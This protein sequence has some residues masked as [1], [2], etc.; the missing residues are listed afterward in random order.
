MITIDRTKASRFSL[1]SG[2]IISKITQLENEC[3][4][5]FEHVHVRNKNDD[6]ES[7][8]SYEK[9]LVL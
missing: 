8:N 6:K 5:D 7:G 3:T 4:I 9:E 1:D 2:G